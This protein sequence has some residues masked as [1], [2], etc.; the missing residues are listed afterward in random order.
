MKKKRILALWGMGLLSVFCLVSA[1]GAETLQGVQQAI[2]AKGADWTAGHTPISQLPPDEFRKRLG[3][4]PPHEF[5]GPEKASLPM[6]LQAPSLPERLDWRNNGGNFVTPVR[7]QGSC[8]GCWSFSAA[9][10]LESYIMISNQ[11]PG[12]S[13]DLAE[14]ILVSCCKECSEW[15]GGCVGGWP[16]IAAEFLREKGLAP[17]SCYP[18]TQSDGECSDAC[19]DWQSSS[20]K[21]VDW[22]WVTTPNKASNVEALK[23]A[24]YAHGPLSV[25]MAVYSDFSYYHGGIYKRTS[26][27]LTGYHAVVLVGYDDQDQYFI[28]KNSWGPDT[29]GESGYMRISYSTVTDC[30]GD[31]N[32]PNNDNP[33][34][35]LGYMALAYSSSPFAGKVTSVNSAS[36][37]GLELARDSIVIAFGSNLAVGPAIATSIPLPAD[38]RGTS[39]KITDNKKKEHLAPLFSVTPGQVN[40]LIPAEVAPGLAAVTITSGN[41]AVSTGSLQVA[42][43]YESY[44]W[45]T[46]ASVAPGLFS[47]NSDGKGVAAAYAVRVK[48]DGSQVYEPVARYDLEQKKFIPLPIDLGL[49]TDQV[50]LI[51]YGTGI[52]L[53]PSPDAAT[54]RIGDVDAPVTYVG[55]QGYFIGLDQINVKLPRSLAGRGEVDVL[56]TVDGKPANPL[57]INIGRLVNKIQPSAL[58]EKRPSRTASPEPDR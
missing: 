23:N 26:S 36:Y 46:Y 55:A 51:L 21:V 15:L 3:V 56:L 34:V 31:L 49:E 9:G 25:S 54:V 19:P 28:M 42:R 35:C 41:G 32:D 53:L 40:Y 38:L 14:Q 44:T 39:V 13:L 20:Q 57:K 29:W 22:N 27:W 18:F 2:A 12:L 24:L 8:G 11:T 58:P 47:A 6:A 30:Q 43:R 5:V 4:R 10:A 1:P 45:E 48:K 33:G 37:S 7:D 52:R 16:H 17:E 50:Y